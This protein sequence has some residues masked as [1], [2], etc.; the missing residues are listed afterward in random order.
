[1]DLLKRLVALRFRI[2]TQ[3]FAAFGVA[4]ALTV[5]A[6]LI[7]WFS[8]QRVGDAQA[9]VNEGSV[10][11]MEAA[12]GVA[13]FSGGLVAAAPRLTTSSDPEELAE[14]WREISIAGEI[15]E[16]HLTALD[17]ADPVRSQRIRGYSDGLNN[18]I[19]TIRVNMGRAFDLNQQS[20][21]LL[22]AMVNLR[23][24]LEQVL[25]PAV[26]DEY[27]YML[28]GRT[29]LGSII[30][31]YALHFSEDEFGTYR[32]LSALQADTSIALQ[33]LSSVFSIFDPNLVEAQEERFES[34]MASIRRNMAS[35]GNDELEQRLAPLYA[36]LEQ[37]GLAS[38]G[39][40]VVLRSRLQLAE[41]QSR[42]LSL[43]SSQSASL[44]AEVDSLV[45]A[46]VVS[47][48]EATQAS[49]QAISTGSTLLIA[50]SVA[51]VL[52]ALLIS[53]LFVGRVL[54]HRINMLSQR[55][56]RMAA[57]ELEE[58]VQ[59]QGQDELAEMAAALE[60]FRHNS[61]EA[62]RL[63]LVEELNTELEGKNTE[64]ESVLSELDGKN[65]ELEGRTASWRW[66]WPTFRRPKTRS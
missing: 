14:V 47:A 33:Q 62:L 51:S 61:Q 17:E 22:D 12:F 48:E 9:R 38:D 26:D 8:F 19:E 49:D 36:R 55:M 4:V 66:S 43:S 13:E 21:A 15:M 42:L 5:A 16:A 11:E 50:I 27:F 37:L 31:P 44:V 39:V 56:R 45:S 23:A 30:A 60:V 24:D 7:G 52:S 20:D 25:I 28:T 65:S 63:N 41:E 18:Y 40:F 53:W 59:V 35:L 1:M 2:S 54:L 32:H 57:G 6:S 46:A 10:P 29:E 64:L 58:E 34:S 3:L